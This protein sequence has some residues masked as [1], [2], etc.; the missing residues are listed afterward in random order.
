MAIGEPKEVSK[1]RR[2]VADKD[3]AVWKDRVEGGRALR[4]TEAA[5]KQGARSTETPDEKKARSAQSPGK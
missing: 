5:Q 4:E 2:D 1:A 3:A